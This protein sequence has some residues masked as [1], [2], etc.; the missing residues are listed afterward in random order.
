MR[1]DSIGISLADLKRA[2]WLLRD[3]AELLEGTG[4]GAVDDVGA[5]LIDDA[6][7]CASRLEKAALPAVK[8]ILIDKR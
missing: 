1:G 4:I 8:F 2:A 7:R 5:A 3:Y 6:A